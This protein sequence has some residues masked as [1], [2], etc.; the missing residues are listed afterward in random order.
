MKKLSTAALVVL[1]ALAAAKLCLYTV[2]E[3]VQAQFGSG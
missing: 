1:V 3:R 2:N